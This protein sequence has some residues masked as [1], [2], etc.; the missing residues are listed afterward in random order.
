MPFLKPYRTMI[1]DKIF[2]YFLKEVYKSLPYE[3]LSKNEESYAK[4]TEIKA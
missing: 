4:R 2:S 1:S 3:I